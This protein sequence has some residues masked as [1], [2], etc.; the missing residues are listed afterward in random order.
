M[1]SSH[2]TKIGRKQSLL[3]PDIIEDYIDKDNPIRMIDAFVDSLD[4]NKMGFRY[5]VLEEGPGR[6]SYDPSDLLKL[7]LWGYYNG[8]RSSRKLEKE[9]KRNIEV[10]WLIRKLT[11]DFKTIADFRKDNVSSIKPV[12]RFFVDACRESGII[13]GNTVGIDGTKVKAWNSRGRNFT[14]DGI[15]KRIDEIDDKIDR[16]LKEMDQN[17]EIEKDERKI[18]DMR[19]RIED[20]RNKVSELRKIRNMMDENSLEE[21]SLTDPESKL[22]KTKNGLDVCL[23]AHIAVESESHMIT[24]YMVNNDTNDHSSLV[25]LTDTSKEILGSVVVTADKGH[26]SLDNL[27]K[28]DAEHVEFYI[29][30]ERRGNP[31]RKVGV[32]TSDYHQ[33]LF[34][35]DRENDAYICPEGK[36]LH[37]WRNFNKKGT[38]FGI[39]K[40]DA[41]LQCTARKMC[42]T[43]RKGR[44]IRRS[45]IAEVE[46]AHRRRMKL[47]GREMMTLRSSVSEHPFGTMKRSMNGAYALLKGVRKFSG[48][49]GLM[50]IAYNLKRLATLNGEK[51]ADGF[52]RINGPK[53]MDIKA[54]V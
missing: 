41:C 10:M 22:M 5:S 39:Y 17:D 23:N 49:F 27:R 42:T 16:Y 29:S 3:L 37:F 4:L 12:F 31:S 1:S 24:D 51:K 14:K 33:S 36:E 25:P 15:G 13:S 43:S 47:M 45:D 50:A 35:Y 20:M 8:I 34:R 46:E 11:P 44:K 6:P 21:I 48:E 40:T 26:Y 54:T 38:N 7:Y 9:C 30:E 32:P 53:T 2:I 18:T 28:L 52:L 19:E